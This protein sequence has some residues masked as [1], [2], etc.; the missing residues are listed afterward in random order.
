MTSATM[1]VVEKTTKGRVCT[2]PTDGLNFQEPPKSC[3]PHEDAVAG[4]RPLYSVRLLALAVERRHVTESTR[5]KVSAAGA[6]VRAKVR[7]APG[8]IHPDHSR[9]RRP[10]GIE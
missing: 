4:Q 3:N 6:L 9:G 2:T 8:V 5:C 10:C 1:R 7:A